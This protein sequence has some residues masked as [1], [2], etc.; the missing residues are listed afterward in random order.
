MRYGFG[1]TRAAAAALVLAVAV[2]CGGCRVGVGQSPSTVPVSPTDGSPGSTLVEGLR[3][4]PGTLLLGAPFPR[5]HGAAALMLVTGDPL[6][7]FRDLVEQAQRGGFGL[8]PQSIIGPCWIST[9]AHNWWHSDHQAALVR[10]V[11]SSVTGLGCAVQG[12]TAPG[13]GRSRS[14]GLRLLVGA[15]ERP[16]L[17]HLSLSYAVAENEV[18][19]A[20]PSPTAPVRI[21]A[22]ASPVM[23]G[24]LTRVAAAGVGLGWRFGTEP[25][26]RIAK[27]TSLLA[28]AFPEPAGCGTSGF[29][30]VL[31]VTGRV[32]PVV[33]DY[34]AQ[35]A[36]A[37]LDRQDRRVLR[38]PSGDTTY[39][40]A[41]TAGGGDATL[42]A[43]IRNGAAYA[44][45]ERC[46]D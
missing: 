31:A 38:T 33:D 32:G 8:Q 45:I 1:M 25:Q 26:L 6:V 40:H 39:L 11:P 17:A 22:L 46:Q 34:A 42:T 41:T 28:P 13:S 12:W 4:P 19:R 9:A 3:S 36:R 44:L 37:G 35:F 7:A 24:P 29:V 20:M 23:P 2:V 14:L 30:A 15:A 10:P 43:I 16:Y 21:P 18:A 27:G 5:P